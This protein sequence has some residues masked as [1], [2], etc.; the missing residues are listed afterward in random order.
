[1]NPESETT[2]KLSSRTARLRTLNLILF[3][4]VQAAVGWSAPGALRLEAES[5]DIPV[6]AT[7]E[8]GVMPADA[9]AGLNGA[10][11]TDVRFSALDADWHVARGWRQT[12]AGGSAN[13][14]WLWSATL[15]PFGLGETSLP[16]VEA[17]LRKPDGTT[18]VIELEGPAITV[19]DG[20]DAADAELRD[21][22]DIH[23]YRFD[24]RWIA[25]WAAAGI[26]GALAALLL[27]RRLMNNRAAA[28]APPPVPPSDWALAEIGRRRALPECRSGHSKRIA[29]E[30]SDVI[31]RFLERRY[32][33]PALEMTT[34]ECLRRL[35]NTHVP[36]GYPRAVKLFLEECDLAK[37]TRVELEPHRKDAI[38]D[39][40]RTLV[41]I[42]VQE[43]NARRR[44][45]AP[46]PEAE[47][48]VS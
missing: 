3:L 31:R 24:R 7:F 22:Q 14:D 8:M 28:P 40:A 33:F 30:A 43:L 23:P 29:S 6:G 44:E 38:W 21:L 47:A 2:F 4:G 17:V 5:S 34:V 20:L 13:E 41:E 48:A 18:E 39:D 27:V 19:V 1:M 9:E 25:L 16:P 15:Q 37:F 46:T 26:F 42:S 11:V 10:T 45:D 32:G 36:A 35:E 12:T